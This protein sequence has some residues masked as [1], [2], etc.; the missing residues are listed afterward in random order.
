MQPYK[1]TYYESVICQFKQG[2]IC[3]IYL[4]ED[5]MSFEVTKLMDKLLFNDYSVETS[6][7]S[8]IGGLKSHSIVNNDNSVIFFKIV[9]KL[10]A[11]SGKKRN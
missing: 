7:L 11:K 10:F 9:K 2:Y 6:I 8:I 3:F 5:R 1:D 4:D